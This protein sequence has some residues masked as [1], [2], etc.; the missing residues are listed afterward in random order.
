MRAPRAPARLPLAWLLLAWLALST[1]GADGQLYRFGKNKVQYDQ[2][3]WQR[4]QTDHFDV[5]F[6]PEE[7]Q[8][9][10]YAARM[11]ETGFRE[12]ERRLGHTVQRRVPLIVYS[13]HVYFEQT[14]VI[15][16]VLPEGVAGFTEFLK[17]RVALPL[18][19]SYPDFERV[20]HHELVHVF[21]FDRIRVVLRGRG[22]HR[23]WFGPLWF[24]EGLAEYL[25]TRPDS[26]GD[27]ILRDA[28]FSQRLASIAQMYRI[29]GTFQMYKEGQSICELM[30]AR[31][32]D[33]VFARLLDNW[34]RGETF[35][36]VFAVTTGQ[37]LADFDEAWMYQLQKRFLPDIET[38]DPPSQ[39]ATAVTQTGYNLKP[40]V[41]PTSAAGRVPADSVAFVFFRNEKGYTSIARQR[42]GDDAPHT[43]V[44]GERQPD[45][46]SLHALHASL[47]VSPDGR[48]LAFVAKRNG[49]D[50][51]ILWD[52]DTGRRLRRY[53][54]DS[55]V[56]L[57]APT[58]SPDGMQLA[59]AGA[60]NG[61]ST[62]LFLVDVE[63]GT[64]TALTDDLY[65]DRDPHWHPHTGHL[66]FSSDRDA[67]NGRQG[68][69]SLFVYE[70]ASGR[71]T[72]L[73]RGAPHDQQPA[74]SPDGERL[75]FSSDRAGFYDLYTLR[76]RI[77]SSG[78]TPL[79]QRRL[80]RTLTG[81]FD[82]AWM[83]SAEELLCTGYE[84][85]RLHVYRVD[86]AQATDSLQA[87]V[88]PDEAPSAPWTL[89]GLQELG[90]VT[91][92]TYRRRLSLDIAQSQISQDPLFGTSGG[93]QIGVSDVL[94]DDRYQ[95]VLSH[96][97]GPSSGFFNGLNVAF[98]RLH[99][100]RRV[101]VSW[102]LF[103][104][105]DR[106]GSSLGRFVREKRTGGWLS[107]SYPFG[108]H[109]RV[110]TEF[111]A[112]HADIDRQFEGRRLSGWLVSNRLSYTHD[113]S[114]WIPTGPLEGER[115]SVGIGQTVDLK[116]SRP[117]NV[118]FFGDYRRYVPL[119]ARV[120]VAARYMA[121]H[122]RGDVPEL[123]ALGGSWTLRGYGFR[124][125][126]GRNL[127]LVNHELRYPLLDRF[128]LGLPFGN[129]D[130]PALRGALFVD[131]GNAWNDDFGA[132]KGSLGAGA[133]L[134]L[135]G[136]FVF[137]LDGARRT[138]FK[139]I[140]NDTLWTFFFGWDF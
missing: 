68:R 53:T 39:M 55:L 84:A 82:P 110:E 88:V 139:S 16:G 91:Q 121:R 23:V 74:W 97:S 132:W 19:G 46:E 24:S 95:F 54:F 26:Y 62:D 57:A 59:L 72:Q 87:A 136:V 79:T 61:G 56:A 114:Y 40:E 63:D 76:V 99:L 129:I 134:G 73:T 85:G 60:R 98:G 135:G 52:L 90:A 41:V 3:D 120:S 140:D 116:R 80:T 127:A 138:D 106:L 96:I 101:N 47:A 78:V 14:N 122:S 8:L 103:R 100:A 86:L 123:F 44:K 137:R 9:A 30:A 50:H 92:H 4:L 69:H 28:L 118:T 17:G 38:T 43:V 34:W 33:D 45:Y 131:A 128:V 22:V 2:F 10:S 32:G 48:Q 75:A 35:E 113:N 104:L 25:S 89:A 27:M 125:L 94:G 133:R 66:A 64:L 49:R 107:L 31:F 5:Y 58:W 6:Y 42:V 37:S 20:L 109:D 124:S 126:W 83:P 67:E 36:E 15:P 108:R 93:I 51:L 115:Y 111:T 7:E 102:G 29:Y 70:L 12:L 13:S 105:N 77:G 112:R 117:F 130:L 18:S 71:V 1:A 65:D 81:L 119:T 21:M 11:A